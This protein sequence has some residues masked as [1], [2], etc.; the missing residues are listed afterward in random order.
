VPGRTRVVSIAVYD[1]VEALEYAA[2]HRLSAVLLAVSFLL[3]LAVFAAGRAN[4][5][6]PR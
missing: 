3:L 6:G 2:A 4:R 5:L 1:H